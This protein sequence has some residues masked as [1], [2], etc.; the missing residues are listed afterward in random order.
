MVDSGSY[1]RVPHF[2]TAFTHSVTNYIAASTSSLSYDLSALFPYPLVAYSSFSHHYNIV[3]KFGELIITWWSPLL[4]SLCSFAF[5]DCFHE[6][7]SFSSS[8]LQYWYWTKKNE[9]A[10]FCEKIE[11]SFAL[12]FFDLEFQLALTSTST[13]KTSQNPVC[14]CGRLYFRLKFV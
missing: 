8:L 1:S 2:S 9:T 10:L 14:V 11:K 3:V 12:L 6:W 7:F 4:C 13:S 5:I